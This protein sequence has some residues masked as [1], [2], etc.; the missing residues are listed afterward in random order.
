MANDC[1]AEYLYRNNGN[2]RFTEV[3]FESG[4]AL[5][6]DGKALANMGV[7]IWRL[8]AHRAF[9]DRDQPFQRSI[10]RALP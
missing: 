6:E 8:P 4:V 9:F 3:G 10:L 5:D 7:A 1:A 2:G